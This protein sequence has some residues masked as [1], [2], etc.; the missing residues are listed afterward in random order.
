MKFGWKIAGWRFAIT[1]FLIVFVSCR[2]PKREADYTSREPIPTSDRNAVQLIITEERFTEPTT[3]ST[4]EEGIPRPI[5]DWQSTEMLRYEIGPTDIVRITMLVG[6]EAKGYEVMVT[7]G[8]TVILPL[9]GPFPLAG[10]TV[11]QAIDEIREAFS[12]YYVDPQ[13]QVRVIA[14]QSKKVYLMGGIGSKTIYSMTKRTTLFEVMNTLQDVI[15]K[16]DLEGAYLMRK[17]KIYPLQLERLLEGDLSTNYEVFHND[18]IY[19]PDRSEMKVYVLGE[20]VKPGM[21]KFEKKDNLFFLLAKAGGLRKGAQL[22]EVR[23]IRGGMEDP[24]L[25]TVN[26]HPLMKRRPSSQLR[27]GNLAAL[28]VSVDVTRKS[29]MSLEKL[30]LQ[31]RDIV[32]VP[33]TALEKWN[34]ILNQ[35]TPTLTFLFTRPILVSRDMLYLQENF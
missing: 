28:A 16:L 35:I 6:L 3:P 1:A 20:V 21:Y 24:T 8:G 9:I 14:F 19:L 5:Q 27:S 25:I 7:A 17:G 34:T 15:S 18:V 10:K 22:R 13:V 2:S 4:M 26:I 23:I 33:M 32:F 12:E 31:D 29:A 11:E 30:Y